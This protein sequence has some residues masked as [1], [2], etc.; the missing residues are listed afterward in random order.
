MLAFASVVPCAVC[1]VLC[2]VPMEDDRRPQSAVQKETKVFLVALGEIPG[3][4]HPPGYIAVGTGAAALGSP[5]LLCADEPR[6]TTPL[7]A[8]SALS[9]DTAS[10]PGRIGRVAV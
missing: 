7:R 3:Q 9:C 5:M 1:C 2:A 4:M 8:S 10:C 6:D